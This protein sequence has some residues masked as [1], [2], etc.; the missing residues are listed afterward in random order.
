MRVLKMV[1]M[2]ICASV[3]GLLLLWGVY[4]LPVEPMVDNVIASEE[5]LKKQDDSEYILAGEYW[6]ATDRGT[7]II[8]LHEIIYP[9]TGNAFQD[10]MLSPTANYSKNWSADWSEVLM[11]YAKTQE[12]GEDDYVSYARYWHGYLVILKPLFSILELD[13]IYF[14]NSIVLIFLVTGVLILLKKKIGSYYLA[15]LICVMMMNP[16][17]IMQSFQLSSVFYSLNITLIMLLFKEWKT[18]QIPYIF[19]MDG[20]LVSFLDFLTYPYVALAIPLL[21][22]YLINRNDSFKSNILIACDNIF[23]F[24]VGYAGMWGMK[25]LFATIFTH[26]NVIFDALASVFHRVGI[27]DKNIKDEVFLSVST[28]DALLRNIGQFFNEQNLIILVILSVFICFYVIRSRE[29]ICINIEHLI[30]CGL[31]ALTPFLW[32]VLLSN[33]CSLHPH[34]EWR[35][36]VV[37]IYAI[38][39]FIISMFDKDR[40]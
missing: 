37:L 18:E 33:H 34:L 19:V 10:A 17:N 5:Y 25:W 14:V 24:V 21:T 16:I 8:I 6:K 32:I 3:I 31:L 27:T 29:K 15:Y 30:V 20:V 40:I 9:N 38:M 1:G 2:V 22:Y 11:R 13:Q 26:E 7:N 36:L 35:T 39:V 23:S 28:K 12:Y 4:L